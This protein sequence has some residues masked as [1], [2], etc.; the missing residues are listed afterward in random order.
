[1]G[2]TNVKAENEPII[3]ALICI[4]DGAYRRLRPVLRHLT[5]GLVDLMAGVRLLS[6]TAEA[7]RLTLGPVQ[8]LIHDSLRWPLRN[9]RFRQ[10]T[11]ALAATPPTV[12]HAMS[13][14]AYQV[15]EMTAAEFD[16]DLVY[17]VTAT[18]DVDAL[19]ATRHAGPRR[20]LCGSQPL[21]DMCIERGVATA[22]ELHLV[23]PGVV[24]GKQI[25]CFVDP[26]RLPTLLSTAPLLPHEGV[27]LIL[28]AVRRLTERGHK[29]LTFLLGAGPHEWVLRRQA[30]RMNLGRTVV[31]A[32]PE[33]DILKAMTGADIFIQPTA[34]RAL[35]ARTLQALAQGMAVTGVG[36]GVCDALIA[37]RTAVLC[38]TP[39]SGEL[40]T[41]IER[42]LLDREFAR[43]VA[44]NAVEHM[45]KHH[46]MSA[47]AQQTADAYKAMAL[48]RATYSI[49]S[50]PH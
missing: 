44:T 15:A 41:G 50:H 23:R 43:T 39:S 4:D 33:G 42:L 38:N 27:D 7:E 25:S 32:Q 24:C 11:E 13:R 31:F 34:E 8:T 2:K 3:N 36:G 21:C 40:A 14:G 20:V 12:V 26:T 45:R 1:M 47:M 29:L 5:V 28:D 19:A 10:I 35:S 9:H 18:D 48:N 6:S 17:Q 37:D 49:A 46:T 22:D 30:R 16:T